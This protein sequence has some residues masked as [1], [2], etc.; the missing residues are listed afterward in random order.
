M[1]ALR[2]VMEYIGAG[3][4]LHHTVVVDGCTGEPSLEISFYMFAMNND[5]GDPI[6]GVGYRE[7]EQKVLVEKVPEGLGSLVDSLD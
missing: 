2:D 7:G 5:T 3:R 4:M 1:M 6:W